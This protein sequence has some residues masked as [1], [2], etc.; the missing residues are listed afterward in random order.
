[1][2]TI[3]WLR[4]GSRIIILFCFPGPGRA[5]SHICFNE[6]VGVPIP[7]AHTVTL[8]SVQESDGSNCFGVN[9]VHHFG[10]MCDPGG[11][12]VACNLTV[13]EAATDT[14]CTKQNGDGWITADPH[15]CRCDI[16][17]HTPAD[18]FKRIKCTATITESVPSF[19]TTGPPIIDGNVD[20]DKG[21]NEAFRYTFDNGTSDYG[22]AFQGNKD[23]QFL[24]LSWQVRNDTVF[25]QNSFVV[26]AFDPDGTGNNIRRYYIFPT[27]H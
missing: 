8:A 13:D 21:W 27:C 17:F 25:D 20:D 18:C 16:M 23:A 24:Y 19:T 3:N 12:R 15:D 11:T 26:F 2:R 1:M 10:R 5:Q 7:T 4:I 9:N 22:A 14:S 6:A